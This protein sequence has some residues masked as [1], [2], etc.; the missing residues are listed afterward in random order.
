[1]FEHR[2]H[3][4]VVCHP[5]F[6]KLKDVEYLGTIGNM[7]L[8]SDY[9]AVLFEGKVQ[10]HMVSCLHVYKLTLCF[11]LS[12]NKPLFSRLHHLLYSL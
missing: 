8:N 2:F 9:A 3:Q 1:M 7:C 5:G 6:L 10:L 4:T 12:T 11:C